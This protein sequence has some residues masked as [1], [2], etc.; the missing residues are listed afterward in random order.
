M[1]PAICFL[2]TDDTNQSRN[3][4]GSC[5]QRSSSRKLLTTSCREQG[6]ALITHVFP[7]IIHFFVP[8]STGFY[9]IFACGLAPWFRRDRR[10]P[11]LVP[12][13][14]FPEDWLVFS[15]PAPS[16]AARVTRE[17]TA[18]RSASAAN[19]KPTSEPPPHP[20]IH[21]NAVFPERRRAPGT[22]PRSTGPSQQPQPLRNPD[23]AR[24]STPPSRGRILPSWP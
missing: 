4:F 24:F 13:P 20:P 22:L 6:V 16:T 11:A 1:L 2:S 7:T 3:I 14:I 5:F 23:R 18:G 21:Q 15:R 10:G 8:I 12:E 9:Q 17:R 19:A